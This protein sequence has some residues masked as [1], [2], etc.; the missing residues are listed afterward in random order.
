MSGDLAI[1]PDDYVVFDDGERPDTNSLTDLCLGTDDRQRMDIHGENLEE[2][3][4]VRRGRI[5]AGTDMRR[6]AEGFIG[7]AVQ[8]GSTG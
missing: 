1:V 4:E 6:L 7:Y 2:V 5:G 8:I 3:G